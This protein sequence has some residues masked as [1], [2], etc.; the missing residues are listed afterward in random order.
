MFIGIILLIAGM[1]GE[2][3][4]VKIKDL[5]TKIITILFCL[6]GV[7]CGIILICMASAEFG[8]QEIREKFTWEITSEQRLLP[9][10]A[11]D[12]GGHIEFNKDGSVNFVGLILGTTVPAK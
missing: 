3:F 12:F 8:R 5:N 4:M 6:A 11:F 7:S 1:M 10:A 9:N 2:F